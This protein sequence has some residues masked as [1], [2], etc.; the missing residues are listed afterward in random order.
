MPLVIAG[1]V[2]LWSS[3]AVFVGKVLVDA[4]GLS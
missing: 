2:L 1:H 4:F 3:F